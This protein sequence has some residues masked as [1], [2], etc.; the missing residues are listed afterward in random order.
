MAEVPCPIIVVDL[1][2]EKAHAS[3]E[4]GHAINILVAGIA[5]RYAVGSR[6]IVEEGTV[7]GTELC[8]I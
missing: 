6:G 7:M 2:G 1:C 8:N 5:K 3:R 4:L